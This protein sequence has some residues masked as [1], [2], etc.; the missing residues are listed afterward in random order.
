MDRRTTP[1]ET[2]T[3]R[4]REDGRRLLAAALLVFC[5]AAGVRLLHLAA[6]SSSPTFGIPVIDARTYHELA[7]A[8]SRQG[9]REPALFW[10]PVG[11]PLFLSAIYSLFGVSVV[12][13]R[14]AGA[15]LGGLTAVVILLLG[16]RVAG[17]GTGLAAG[18]I[19]AFYGPAVFFDTELL[20]TGQAA[21]WGAALPLLVLSC[22]S[23]P[24][25][26][27]Q[28]P[29]LALLL[30]L[31][32][33]A[34]FLVRTTFGPY[35]ALAAIW[36]VVRW[37]R[38]R[39]SWPRI[40]GHGLLAAAGLAAVLLPVAITSL[41]LTDHLVLAPPSGGL[42][43]YIGNNPDFAQ[44]VTVRPGLPWTELRSLPAR[45]VQEGDVF[46]RRDWFLAR[47][48]R[49]IQR[50]PLAFVRLLGRKSLHLISSRELPRNVDIYLLRAE[51][52]VI[53]LLVWKAGRFGFPFG[54]LLPLAVLGLWLGRPRAPAPV[55]LLPLTKG[56]VLVLFFVSA[57]YRLALVPVLCVLAAQ[58]GAAL[59]RRARA[60]QRGELLRAGAATL[61]VLL[62]ATVPGPFAQERTDL[63]PE[64]DFA[65]GYGHFAEGQWSQAVPFLERAIAS[66]PDYAEAHNFLGIALYRLGRLREAAD[67]LRAAV[68]SHPGYRDARVNLEILHREARQLAEQARP[69]VE[70]SRWQAAL[71]LLARAAALQPD[72]P[73]RWA[74]LA[75]AQAAL[76]DTAAALHSWQEALRLQ[77]GWPEA[78]EALRRLE[79]G[80]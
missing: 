63:A 29:L 12:A 1:T 28:T 50:Q 35:L 9:I 32:G 7:K 69:L 3:G 72:S 41:R 19:W 38:Q 66:R 46:A 52:L 31:A 8:I 57:R 26:G 80:Q 59:W 55:W 42:N 27:R 24:A 71:P 2:N 44:T 53:R 68:Q 40:A 36:L 45:E 16:R 11:Y 47:T 18:L 49:F 43:L 78:G 5:L 54:L 60:R 10:Q 25:R 33:G 15:L 51:S 22:A 20:A 30:G 76:A 74:Q 6:S 75:R 64:L 13:A 56:V 70:Q 37:R 73:A 4:A 79:A 62:L 77:P 48:W 39:R 23:P 21:F 65:L 14:V 17:P 67:H 61:A 58:G 34:A